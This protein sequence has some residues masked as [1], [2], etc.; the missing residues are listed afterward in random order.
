MAVVGVSGAVTKTSLLSI[1]RQV[2]NFGADEQYA[3]VRG[4]V[5]GSFVSTLL[6]EK[7]SHGESSGNSIW[8]I[9]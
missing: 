2:W 8:R 3:P 5:V 6:K 7:R 4:L 9:N 1:A